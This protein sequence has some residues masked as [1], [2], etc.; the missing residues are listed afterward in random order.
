MRKIKELIIFISQKIFT[1]HSLIPTRTLPNILTYMYMYIS[2]KYVGVIDTL[3]GFTVAFVGAH[4][5]EQ[6]WSTLLDN[7]ESPSAKVDLKKKRT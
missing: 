1:Y 5:S 4:A 7:L 2:Y 6:K 3:S